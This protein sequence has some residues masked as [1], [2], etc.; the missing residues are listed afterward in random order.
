MQLVLTQLFAWPKLLS[1]KSSDDGK[2]CF[3]LDWA[4]APKDPIAAGQ[5]ES[6]FLQVDKVFLVKVD[7]AD[8]MS[9]SFVVTSYAGPSQTV[10]CG[11]YMSY[12][13]AVG[14]GKY[15]LPEFLKR[16]LGFAPKPDRDISMTDFTQTLSTLFQADVT[17]TEFRKAWQT[18]F[19]CGPG[20]SPRLKQALV[21]V[22][23]RTV[24]PPDRFLDQLEKQ[25]PK[26]PHGC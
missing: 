10:C 25:W 24:L 17:E 3:D 11:L 23:D 16:N 21:K 6:L 26:C 2:I 7:L 22:L 1:A 5:L 8:G 4:D 15:T 20:N 19:G 13:T 9:H 14:G 12:A 18:L